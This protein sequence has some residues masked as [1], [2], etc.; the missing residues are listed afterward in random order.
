MIQKINHRKFFIVTTIPASLNFFKGQLAYINNDYEVV[1]ISSEKELLERFGKEEGIDTFYISM[2]R[3]I[4]LWH[5]F[6]SLMKF[7]LLFR[8]SKPDIVHGNTPKGS[9]L[10]MVAAKL[11]G[12]PVRIYMCHGLRYQGYSSMMKFLLKTMERISC[13]CATQVFCVSNGVKATLMAD[14]ICKAAKLKVVG[15]GS[16]NGIDTVKFDR[17]NIPMDTVLSIVD[18]YDNKFVFC[19]V[20]RLVKDKGVNELVSAFKRLAGIY[21]DIKLILVGPLEDNENAI[22]E[23]TKKEINSNSNIVFWGRQKDIRPFMCA[24]DVF[25]LPSYREGFGVVLMEAGALGIPCITTDIIG[26]NEII[27]D[28]VNGKIIPPRN[29]EALYNVMKWMYDHRDN[30]VKGMAR[31]ARSLVVKR[32][33]QVMVWNAMLKEYHSLEK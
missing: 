27:R 14:D 26:C 13:Y 25:V 6:K 9:L 10:S 20:G 31:C 15:N 8:K 22:D 16:A 17:K 1:A 5:D 24:S 30:E 18:T 33:E 4:S 32:Y 11:T 7:L 28:G 23:S 29:E 19:F 12:V 3:P 2:K 21:N